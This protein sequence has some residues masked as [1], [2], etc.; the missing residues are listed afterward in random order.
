M[1][2]STGR[3]LVV[4]R[5]DNE[6]EVVETLEPATGTVPVETVSSIPEA[7]S[8]LE[9]EQIICIVSFIEVRDERGN[10]WI[11][12][13][14]F[15]ERVTAREEN[16][17]FV[18]ISETGNE[19][20]VETALDAGVSDLV[21]PWPG[22]RAER[23]LTEIVEQ[24]V[25]RRRIFTTVDAVTQ[26]NL[27]VRIDAANLD[28]DFSEI[29]TRVNRMIDSI[30]EDVQ[31]REAVAHD[32]DGSIQGLRA[33][34]EQV[35]DSSSE[36]T[37]ATRD[38]TTRIEQANDEV[39]TLSATVE[40]IASTSDEVAKTSEQAVDAADAGQESAESAMDAMENIDEAATEVAEDV[41]SLQERVDEIDE[42]VE[43]INDIAD[44]T[45]ILALNANIEAA[46]AGEAGSG[47]AVVA[48]EVKN[49]ATE[50]QEHAE[51]IERMLD[52]VQEDT[53]TTV[54]SLEEATDEIETGVEE[55]GS[56]MDAL[57]E[58]AETIREATTGI[59][60]VAS[61]TDDQAASAAEVANMMDQ[62]AEMA[63]ET[64]DEIREIADANTEQVD[65]IG[66][67]EQSM[68]RLVEEDGAETAARLETTATD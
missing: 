37:D 35:A 8:A 68:R 31:R 36:I 55:V 41:R 20:I 49:L 17:P 11:S 23:D 2:A 1:A 40:E 45:N 5:P 10:E 43:L 39:S 56:T 54:E 47:F 33:R 27:D 59:E 48:N 22:E 3:V 53:E 16:V 66:Q 21:R 15:Y 58:I 51:T 26:G 18:L 29:A 7:E 4:C 24:I 9:S 34:S 19:D 44:Q 52:G 38:M 62:I 67:I 25:T 65:E 28:G 42:I 63:E 30:Q 12:G 32:L 14:K 50:A 60:E 57:D 46:R 61:A 6:Q 64:A 13:I